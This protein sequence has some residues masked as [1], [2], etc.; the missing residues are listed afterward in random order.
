MNYEYIAYGLSLLSDAEIPGLSEATTVATPGAVSLSIKAKP[1]WLSET[2]RLPSE[3]IHPLPA[4][5]ECA[6]PAFVVLSFGGGRFFQLRYSDG[7]EFFVDGGAD[8]VWGNCP[9]P[10]TIEDLSTYLLGPVLG[11]V[12][13]RRGV[14][15]LHGSSVSIDNAAV[16][17]AGP[18]GAG[19]STTAAALAL[20]GAPVLCEDIAALEEVEGQFYVQSGY[21]RVCLWPDTVEKLMGSKDALPDLTPTWDKKYLGL[22]GARA[23]FESHKM[24]LGA[25]YLLSERISEEVAPRLEEISGR[26]ALLELVSNTYMNLFLTR[27][28][29]A[30]EFELLS[31]LVN[32][33]PCKRLIPHGDATRIGRLCDLIESDARKAVEEPPPI[34]VQ[35]E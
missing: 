4:T 14:T 8:R 24:P 11:F 33:V 21:P 18:A 20:R 13:R 12:L 15:P 7:A 26:E 19:K 32:C 29:R 9:F 16:I 2:P 28:Q 6:D 30:A 22:D 34:A 17:I 35:Q 5:S 25:I 27:E 31:R 1:E 23:K 10:L 3:V